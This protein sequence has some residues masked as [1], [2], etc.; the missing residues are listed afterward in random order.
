MAGDPRQTIVAE[1]VTE[2]VEERVRHSP[3]DAFSI[4]DV[5]SAVTAM[6]R[7]ASV[8]AAIEPDDEKWIADWLDQHPFLLQ[9]NAGSTAQWRPGLNK[10]RLTGA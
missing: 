6:L 8:L 3:L 1:L 10:D 9:Q 5:T 2:F 4:G 7:E